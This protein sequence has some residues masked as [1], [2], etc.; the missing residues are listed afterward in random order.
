M[1]HLTL[2]FASI[3]GGLAVVFGAFG[4]HALKET[5]LGSGRIETYETAIKY[6]F[7]HSLALI[8]VGILSKEFTNKWLYYSGNC[9]I[10]GTIIFDILIFLVRIFLEGYNRNYHILGFFL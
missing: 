4:A 1:I 7:Y 8:L 9:F 10:I 3:L 5:L 2:L 6:F